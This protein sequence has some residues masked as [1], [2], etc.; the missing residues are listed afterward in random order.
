MN[1][2]YKPMLA[3]TADAPF[4]SK[5]WLF[6]IKWDGFRAISYID[7]RLNIK[8]RNDKELKTNFPELE[9]LKNLTRGV[10]LDGEIVVMRR[11]RPD[12][13]TLLERGKTTSPTDIEYMS[14]KYPAT[15][16]VFDIL[17]KDRR[18]LINLP[19]ID[20]KMILKDSLN[21][22][23]HVLRSLFIEEQGKDYYR[24]SVRR[25]LEGIMAKRRDS[26]YEPG[27]RSGNWLKIK[28]VRSCDCVIFGYTVGEG[29]REETFG[30]LILGLYEDD[31]PVYVGKVGTGFSEDDTPLLKKIFK[32]LEVRKETLH[33]VDV[34]QE[35]VWLKPKLVCEVAYQTVTKDEKLRM[36]RFRGLKAD[37][38]PHECTLDQVKRR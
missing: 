28:K 27:R 35:I 32:G 26:P 12:F 19:L 8:S 17:E 15:Y 1:R 25:A 33:E 7:R 2:H 11:G 34:P 22:G 31:K 14:R 24:A 10:V 36:P 16:V 9:E 29:S 20:R 30:A 38:T 37:K 5:G 21:E 23:R 18:T 13:E 3:Q 6:E 4:N